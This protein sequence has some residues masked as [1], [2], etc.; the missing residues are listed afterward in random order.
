MLRVEVIVLVKDVEEFMINILLLGVLAIVD[1]VKKEIHIMILLPIM[2]VWLFMTLWN[3]KIEVQGI[4]AVVILI[5]FSLLTRQAFGMADAI[6]LSL[7]AMTSGIF[8][9]LMILFTANIFFLVFA[10]VKYGINKK[11]REIPFIPFIFVAF[12]CASL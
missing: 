2:A 9:M 4:I 1:F 12:I 10:T 5:A 8:N 6:V 7:I 11:N 3:G